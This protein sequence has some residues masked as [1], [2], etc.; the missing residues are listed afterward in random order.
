MN[1]FVNSG[2]SAAPKVPQL[3]IIARIIIYIEE[4]EPV[5]TIA[6]SKEVE[7]IAYFSKEGTLVGREYMPLPEGYNP[8]LVLTYG[9]QNDDYTK[10]NKDKVLSIEKLARTL[11]KLS[12]EKVQYVDMRVPNDIFVKLTSTK[13][14]IGE[15]DSTAYNR[16]KDIKSLLDKKKAS[17]KEVQYIDVSWGEAKYFKRGPEEKENEDGDINNEENSNSPNQ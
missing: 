1:F 16:I 8:I 15:L 10:W 6:P 11:E 3:I 7:P 4:R 2:I 14:R 5:L 17:E 9:N 13:I 12:G